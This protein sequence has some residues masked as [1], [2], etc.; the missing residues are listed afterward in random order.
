MFLC[1]DVDL[2]LLK[3]QLIAALQVGK[4]G[5]LSAKMHNPRLKHVLENLLFRF[6]TLEMHPIYKK[7]AWYVCWCRCAARSHGATRCVR[8]HKRNYF[9]HLERERDVVRRLA[10]NLLLPSQG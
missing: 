7:T 9:A 8:M 10:R 3:E 6:Y 1:S 2:Q 5:Q 4:L